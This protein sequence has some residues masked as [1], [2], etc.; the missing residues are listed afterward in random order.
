MRK[1]L[2]YT[3]YL[4]EG[5]TEMELEVPDDTIVYLT[6]SGHGIEDFRFYALI[7][8]SEKVKADMCFLIGNY[9]F[10]FLRRV[11]FSE[12]GL[13][14]KS[15]TECEPP[16]DCYIVFLQK[17]RFTL[18]ETARILEACKSENGETDWE[19]LKEFRMSIE[20]ISKIKKFTD[21]GIETVHLDFKD[22]VGQDQVSVSLFTWDYDHTWEGD[23]PCNSCNFFTTEEK[24]KQLFNDKLEEYYKLFKE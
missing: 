10:T 7:R 6:G 13:P 20:G 17:R 18:Q 1:T 2:K 21:R 15:V 16:T 8:T 4:Y 5:S 19:K 22:L 3:Q 9:W 14:C 23:Q 12:C 11:S 24:Y